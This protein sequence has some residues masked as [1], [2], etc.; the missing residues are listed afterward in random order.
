MARR[1]SSFVKE[2]CI[3]SPVP[4]TNFVLKNGFKRGIE[5]KFIKILLKV[6]IN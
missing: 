1:E 4:I 2:F 6:K 3:K 5:Y